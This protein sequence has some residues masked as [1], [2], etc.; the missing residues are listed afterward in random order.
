M[1]EFCKACKSSLP[2]ADITFTDGEM[3]ASHD[4]LCPFCKE[5]ANPAPVKHSQTHAPP[6]PSEENDVL[7]KDGQSTLVEQEA[8]EAEAPS[9]A[10]DEP[11]VEEAADDPATDP[12]TDPVIED[13]IE[14]PAEEPKTEPQ[15]APESTDS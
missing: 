11:A 8:V 10:P 1:V 2:K 13:A 5:P 3:F 4:Y 14:V 7:I 9:T 15:P 6:S 12:A